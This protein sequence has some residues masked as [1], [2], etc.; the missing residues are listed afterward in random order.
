MLGEGAAPGDIAALRH[1]YGLDV[2]L[3]QQYLHYWR[4]VARLDFGHS[5]R[6]NV[7]GFLLDRFDRIPREGDCTEF[8]GRR[9]S[10]I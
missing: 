6:L 8:E 1:T 10:V 7:A 5:I 3:G 4:G 9:I 2:P